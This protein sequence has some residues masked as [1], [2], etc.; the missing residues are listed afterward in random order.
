MKWFKFE[1]QEEEIVE[2]ETSPVLV[3]LSPEALKH[4]FI[5]DDFGT[6]NVPKSSTIT[7]CL[8]S[9]VLKYTKTGDVSTSSIY[10]S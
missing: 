6:W 2:A 10:F 7:V 1:P 5:V 4:T 9:S 3:Y 8:S